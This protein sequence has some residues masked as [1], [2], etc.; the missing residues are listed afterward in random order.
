MAQSNYDILGIPDGSSMQRIRIAFRE[1]VL[2][3]HSDRGGHDESF[4]LIKQAFE[5]LKAGKKF[6]DTPEEHVKKSKFFWGT[7][8]EEKKRKNTILSIMKR[9][10]LFLHEQFIIYFRLSRYFKIY[11]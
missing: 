4:I 2:K 10:I 7:D 8:E 11:K 6:P 9:H 1:L 3:N 5:D